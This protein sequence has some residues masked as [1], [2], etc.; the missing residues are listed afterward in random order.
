[1]PTLLKQKKFE[2]VSQALP[3]DTFGVVNFK[4][5]EGFSTCY[6]FEI[7]LVAGDPEIDLA[8]V[9]QNPAVF[10]ILRD[11]GD[12]PFHGILSQFEQ[13]HSVDEFVFYQA[14]LVP[15]LWWLSLT[16]HNQIFL[17][18]TAPQIIEAVLQDGGLTPLDFELKL[19]N[20]YPTW[21]YIC[22]YRE[23][24]LNFVSRWME[25]EGMYYYFEQTADGEKVIITD[26]NLS[27]TA[28]AEGQT[29]YYSPPSGLDERHREEV[30]HALICKQKLLP[31]KLHVQ[32]YN[33][34][35]PSVNLSA[36]AS[37]S[38]QGRGE[39][40]IYGEHFRTLQE[41]SGLAN[42][43][44]Q[45]LQSHEKRFRGESTIP[46]LRTGYRFDLDRHYRDSFNQP[47]LT[48][49]LSHEGSQTGYLVSGIRETLSETEKRPYYRNNFVTIPGNIQY[50]HPKTTPKPHFHGTI[51]AR[52][53]AAGSG[54]YA[55]LDEQGRYKVVL[56]FDLSGRREGKASHWMRMAQPY[57][58]ENQGMHFPL[59]KHTEVLLTFIEGD[60][61]RPIIASAIPNPESPSP[62]STQNQTK[63]IIQTGKGPATS[64][65]GAKYVD[66]RAGKGSKSSNNYI[67]F[68][69]TEFSEKIHIHSPGNFW[70]EAQNR[71]GEYH[72][73][74]LVRPNPNA[75][76]PDP[77]PEPKIADLLKNFDKKD[78]TTTPKGPK[79]PY[80][81]TGMLDRHNSHVDQTDFH[82]DY[83][84]KH[85]FTSLPLTPST[86]RKAMSMILAAI[87]YITWGMPI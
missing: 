84:K 36:E 58:G 16:H 20:S 5:S 9:L 71:Y 67:E 19:Q 48:I 21:E 76:P 24:H 62:V 77:S 14:V 65:V 43:R 35:T 66:G 42:I 3:E 87:G 79:G 85:M 6:Q 74:E 69:D 38:T 86:P 51:N 78:N 27:H 40:H 13:L 56:P 2:F 81:P 49:E 83:L 80:Y 73:R 64:S 39:V 37:V 4:G 54:E 70:R 1:M 29:M 47:Y 28:M 10:T 15:K 68:D 34:R 12:I 23:S 45:E 57:A 30:I 22:Q 18:K 61:D 52:I 7:M 31:G 55:Q 63:S 72:A 46:Y 26:T 50:R 75:T 11:D 8:A 25:R 59:H 60:P 17:D 33:Y 82:D 53:D 32:D 44:V 41:G